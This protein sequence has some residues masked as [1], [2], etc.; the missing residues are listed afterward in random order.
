MDFS[1]EIQKYSLFKLFSKHKP[2]FAQN[3]VVTALHSALSSA[4]QCE[5]HHTYI[6]NY[7]L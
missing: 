5:S 3:T 1:K 4:K 7:T 2:L 6:T